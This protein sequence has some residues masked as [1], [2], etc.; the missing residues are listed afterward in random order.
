VSDRWTRTDNRTRHDGKENHDLNGP[1]ISL[2]PTTMKPR[3]NVTAEDQAVKN[4]DLGKLSFDEQKEAIRR[5]NS[6]LLAR[7]LSAIEAG[8][9]DDSTINA[10]GKVST[11]AKQWMT[12]E[13][14]GGKGIDYDKVP[15]DQLAAAAAKA[16]DPA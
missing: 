3:T 11:I 8:K 5:A 1:V 4:D 10:L 7:T 15:V 2:D 6:I 12:E 16:H 9:T 13:R 14:Q